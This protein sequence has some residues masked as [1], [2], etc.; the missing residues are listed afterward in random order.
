VDD[1]V[2]ETVIVFTDDPN[3]PQLA[4]SF[5]ARVVQ[6]SGDPIHRPY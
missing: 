4:L 3:H 5:T 2:A 1:E 6:P